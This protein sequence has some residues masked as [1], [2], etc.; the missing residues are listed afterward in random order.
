MALIFI[1]Y[2]SLPVFCFFQPLLALN[3][4][5][6]CINWFHDTYIRWLLRNRCARKEQAPLFDLFKAFPTWIFFVH[7]KDLS[8]MRAQ[9]VLSYHL[10]W[11][12]WLNINDFLMA[13]VEKSR[14][15]HFLWLLAA[16]IDKAAFTFRFFKKLN[17]FFSF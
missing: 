10:I 11:A 4:C 9:H 5:T 6:N 15:V 3:A 8:F 13:H 2:I 17:V 1:S 16:H 12:P 7:R 14:N